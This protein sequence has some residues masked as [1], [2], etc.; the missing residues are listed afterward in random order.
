VKTIANPEFV[1][2]LMKDGVK[3]TTQRVFPE[4]LQVFKQALY[5]LTCLSAEDQKPMN[6]AMEMCRS[7]VLGLLI[8]LKRRELI[9]GDIASCQDSATVVKYLE[10]TAYS[11]VL[12]HRHK[13][14][15][16]RS[17]ITAAYKSQCFILAASFCRRF[18]QANF[19]GR[20]SADE[21]SRVRNV[22]DDCESK[23]TD[24]HQIRFDKTSVSPETGFRLCAIDFTLID[25][26]SQY[27]HCPCCGAQAQTSYKGRLCVV[28]DLC[29]L[30]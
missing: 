4:A 22:L 17:A 2:N 23:G 12:M 6:D 11:T 26:A 18:L 13:Y 9:Q 8:E 3:L 29:E 14:A 30:I 27:A 10:Y 5:L 28:C 1:W 24:A 21:V 19:G 25:E 16:L 7:Y 20:A 15:A